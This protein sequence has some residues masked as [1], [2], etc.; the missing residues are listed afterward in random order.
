V[1]ETCRRQDRNVFDWL[2]EAV[3]AK[4]RKETAPSLLTNV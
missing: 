2:T 3:Q 4:L 1:I